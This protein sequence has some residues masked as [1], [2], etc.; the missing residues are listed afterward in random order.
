ML[1]ASIDLFTIPIV[2]IF[3]IKISFRKTYFYLA[4]INL[5]YKSRNDFLQ[6]QHYIIVKIENSYVTQLSIQMHHKISEYLTAL[7]DYQGRK[8]STQQ[9]TFVS[10][11]PLNVYTKDE[12]AA[13]NSI[14]KVSFKLYLS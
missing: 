14:L 9:K 13:R 1:W 4:C 2:L 8:I 7:R 6:L 12:I 11:L 3:I 5:F 10:P